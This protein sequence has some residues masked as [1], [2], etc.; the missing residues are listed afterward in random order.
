MP[1][2][3]TD[4]SICINEAS[5][6]NASLYFTWIRLKASPSNLFWANALFPSIA[7]S[8]RWKKRTPDEISGAWVHKYKN[9]QTHTAKPNNKET[10]KNKQKSPQNQTPMENTSLHYSCISSA[11]SLVQSI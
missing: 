8:N 11:A 9:K 7:R 6:S 2:I 1:Q 10:H 3:S 4:K 5:I